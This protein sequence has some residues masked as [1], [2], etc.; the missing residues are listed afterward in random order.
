MKANLVLITLLASYYLLLECEISSLL[1][2]TLFPVIQFITFAL[3]ALI[4]SG[5]HQLTCIICR[6]VDL[7]RSHYPQ[8][9]Q[10]YSSPV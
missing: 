4:V 1:N 3:K 2:T 5:M 9:C 8:R 10:H 6:E 7:V